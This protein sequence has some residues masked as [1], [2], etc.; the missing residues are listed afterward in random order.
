MRPRALVGLGLLVVGASLQAGCRR[1]QHSA[2]RPRPALGAVVVQDVGSATSTASIDRAALEEKLRR[3]L[4][5]SSLLSDP[6]DA[7]AGAVATLRAEIETEPVQVG[8]KGEARA[9]V[10]LRLTTR[11]ADGAGALSFDLQGQGSMPYRLASSGPG[12]AGQPDAP[13]A[14]ALDALV[15][16]IAGDLIDRYLAQQR[17]ADGPPELVRA[18]IAAS[19]GGELRLEAIRQV[20]E[21]RLQ[22][23][24]PVLLKLLSDPDE[25]TRDTALGALIALHD[26]R[27]VTE[28]ANTRSLRDRREMRK[29]IAAIALLG[30]QEADDY[31]SFV[32]AS[33]D[34]DEIRAAAASARAELQKRRGDDANKPP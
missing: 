4:L 16:R 12:S 28:L 22:D 26:R 17:L 21:R 10:H 19:D 34:D 25:T 32:A 8:D 2:L 33:H 18:A 29:I 15:S 1:G 31:L 5:E 27:A 6:A 30:G 14:A 23:Q 24:A 13:A 7:A 3:R 20:G 11:P 9:R